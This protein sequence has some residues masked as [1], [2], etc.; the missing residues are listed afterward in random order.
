LEAETFIDIN[1]HMN[2]HL[3]GIGGAGMSGLALLLHSMGHIVSGCDA[4]NS[5]YVE[6][7]R[8]EGVDVSMGHHKAH[9]DLYKPELIIHTSAI[10]QDHPELI[11]AHK[12][13][14]A[15]ARRAEILSLI[16]NSRFG[17]GVAGTH[18]KT[19]TSSMISLVAE[20]AGLDPTVAIGGEL[21]DI[22]CNAKLG[23][24]EYMVAELDESD[25]SFGFFSPSVT[26]ITNIDW[27]HVDHYPTYDSV[28]EAFDRFALGSKPGAHN[29][30][31]ARLA[32]KRKPVESFE[33]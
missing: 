14:I 19:T 33:N 23:K 13:G 16:F 8:R 3:M 31:C 26:V 29:Y 6:K 5:F 2:I 24:G 9:L 21:S 4:E 25:G 7:V 10:A 30:R 18:G 28:L 17:V 20:L 12:R 27:D 32:S 11:E 15:V 22:G 1:K